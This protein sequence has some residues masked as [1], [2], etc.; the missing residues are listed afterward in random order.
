VRDQRSGK[1]LREEHES[2]DVE[3]WIAE[4][5]GLMWRDAG[6]LRDGIGLRRA[7]AELDAMRAS[8]PKNVTRRAIE[9]RNLHT[10]AAVIVQAALGR[11]ESRGAHLRLDFPSKA[12][13]ARHSTVKRSELQFV[14]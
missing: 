4:V 10:V 2:D 13:V 3:G 7:Q 6:L 11:E 5:R 8:M 1:A 14:E 12:D 9:A